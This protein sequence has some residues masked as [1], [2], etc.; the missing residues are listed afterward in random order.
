MD[1][2]KGEGGIPAEEHT[3]AK[4]NSVEA[5]K[6]ESA[7]SSSILNKV[8]LNSDGSICEDCAR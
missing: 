5:D 4:L 2:K 8:K 7:E 3:A 1:G 6:S